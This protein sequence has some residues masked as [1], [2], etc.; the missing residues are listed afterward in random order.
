MS[1]ILTI[2]AILGRGG[3][4]A[5]VIGAAYEARAPQLTMAEAVR[6]AVLSRTPLV[7]EAGTGTGKSLAY[8]AG[9]L[10]AGAR[11]VVSTSSKALQGQL[12]NKDL[13]LLARGL[14]QLAFAAAKGRSISSH[15]IRTSFS[16][17]ASH[18][19]PAQLGN[20]PVITERCAFASSSRV[21][22]KRFRS[23]RNASWSTSARRASS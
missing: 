2:P 4:L 16:S 9:G 15:Y 20:R 10:A 21:R 6:Q 1:A 19:L 17:S 7:V 13:P 14:G 5:Q 23:F 12:L 3:R 8:L 18:P 22:F 11:L